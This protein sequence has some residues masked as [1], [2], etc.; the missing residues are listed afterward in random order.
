MKKEAI[1]VG[2]VGVKSKPDSPDVVRRVYWC[3]NLERERLLLGYYP[4]IKKLT[5]SV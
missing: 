4:V 1:F 5:L 3:I 2:E